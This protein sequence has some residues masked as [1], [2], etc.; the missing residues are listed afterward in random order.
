VHHH[1]I[2]SL[3]I[4]AILSAAAI[5]TTVA[6]AFADGGQGPFPR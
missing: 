1:R 3:I 4:S 6:T 2:R 5:L